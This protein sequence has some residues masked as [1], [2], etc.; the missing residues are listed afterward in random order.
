[1]RLL[2]VTGHGV[3]ILGAALGIETVAAAAIPG[4][5]RLLPLGLRL[6]QLRTGG[7][8]CGALLLI[9]AILVS[10]SSR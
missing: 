1:M 10:N 7:V 4:L 9:G 2:R 6:L 8:L 5:A 3:G